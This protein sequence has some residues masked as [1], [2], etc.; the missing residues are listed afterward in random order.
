MKPVLDRKKLR[1]EY[2][3]K[4]GEAYTKG[5]VAGLLLL[6]SLAISLV[7]TLLC[8]KLC[9][10]PP[11]NWGTLFCAFICVVWWLVAVAC[12]EACRR[13]AT[14][15]KNIPYVP[16]VTPSTLPAEEVLVRSAQEPSAPSETLRAGVKGE[17]TEAEELLR[18]SQGG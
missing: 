8:V 16:P 2:L 11:Y 18:S 5:T 13:H 7:L 4:K 9:M 15:A 12:W 1:W 10:L 6:P 17:E 3:R 14:A